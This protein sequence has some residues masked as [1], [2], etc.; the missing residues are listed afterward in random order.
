MQTARARR[1][2]ALLTV[3]SARRMNM[4]RALVRNLKDFAQIVSGFG[5]GIAAIH[6]LNN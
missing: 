4:G 1:S 5:I 6:S 2:T 3:P